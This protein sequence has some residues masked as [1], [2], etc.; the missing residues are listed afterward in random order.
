MST[1]QPDEHR[2]GRRTYV[3][4]PVE[5]LDTD[6]VRTV[7]VGTLVFAVAF[8]ALLPFYGWLEQTDRTWW[9]WTCLAGAGLGLLGLEYVRRRRDRRLA[10]A[11]AGTTP[12]PTA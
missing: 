10:A 9:L 11:D 6:G 5:P 8:V 2:I 12:G 1:D 4:A 7:A 3:I